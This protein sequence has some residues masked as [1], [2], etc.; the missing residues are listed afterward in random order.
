MDSI[1]STRADRL[2]FLG[3]IFNFGNVYISVGSAEL[4]FEDVYDPVA[5]Q[6][7]VDMRRLAAKARKQEA[8]DR[9]ERE[10]MAEWLATY[11]KN[12][13]DLGSADDLLNQRQNPE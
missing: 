1:L 2:G 12:F 11:H 9:A 6:L 13:G 10:N 5:V 3:Y 8:K 7:D 4:V